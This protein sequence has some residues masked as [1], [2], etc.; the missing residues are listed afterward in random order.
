V[1]SLGWAGKL[2]V[3]NVAWPDLAASMYL[4][5][6]RGG[7]WHAT[8]VDLTSSIYNDP[9]TPIYNEVKVRRGTY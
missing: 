6:V 3:S 1:A 9:T 8:Y 7:I 2:L 4:V 5:L